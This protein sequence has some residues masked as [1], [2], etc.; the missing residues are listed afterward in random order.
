VI[1]GAA[2]LIDAAAVGGAHGEDLD[3]GDLGGVA[4]EG[5]AAQGVVNTVASVGP[6]GILKAHVKGGTLAEPIAV[7]PPEGPNPEVLMSG[8][9]E[10]VQSVS[11]DASVLGLG[12]D[13][14]ELGVDTAGS[15][16]FELVNVVDSEE[17]LL[18]GA[19]DD[20]SVS[21]VIGGDTVGNGDGKETFTCDQGVNLGVCQD[22]QEG[23]T[24]VEGPSQ[25]APVDGVTV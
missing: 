9:N 24:I 17:D 6:R 12:S 11:R 16:D 8:G 21:V 10:V 14:S 19:L 23:L 13:Q 15:R 18:L 22:E 25:H 3:V 4:E 7:D 1:S 20:D 5:R 2:A